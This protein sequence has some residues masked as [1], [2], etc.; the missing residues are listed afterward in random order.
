MKSILN[1][2][3][4]S[5]IT[6]NNMKKYLA[7]LAVFIGI[8]SLS[9]G[10]VYAQDYDP[11]VDS[12]VQ[13]VSDPV[14]DNPISN[15]PWNNVTTN[16]PSQSSAYS[17]LYNYG[18]GDANGLQ[19]NGA[20]RSTGTQSGANRTTNGG[21][22]SSPSG[23]GVSSPSGGGGSP[24]GGVGSSPSGGGGGMTQSA[25]PNNFQAAAP[26]NIK[27]GG[28]VN[29]NTDTGKSVTRSRQALLTIC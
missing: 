22:G 6:H 10:V 26:N 27:A 29:C 16:T 28:G 19:L 21:V 12:S 17:G 4:L 24:S 25:A 14:Y 9:G 2:T 13:N 7:I 23:G 11:S 1:L 20:S 5:L 18:A 8:I 15:S 3:I